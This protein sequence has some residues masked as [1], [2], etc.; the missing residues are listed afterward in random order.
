[1]CN[2]AI[3]LALLLVAC[4]ADDAPLGRLP[5]PVG[6]D[7]GTGAGGA[8]GAPIEDAGPDAPVDAGCDAW[9]TEGCCVPSDFCQDTPCE[10]ERLLCGGDCVGHAN[11]S[12]PASCDGKGGTCAGTECVPLDAGKDANG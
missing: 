9:A 11:P 3:L 4:S 10:V 7:A 6:P 12:P 2:R 1:M 5:R 8:G